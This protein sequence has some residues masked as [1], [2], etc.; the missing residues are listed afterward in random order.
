MLALNVFFFHPFHAIKL[1]I[2]E[3][4]RDLLPENDFR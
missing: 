4:D 1:V 2:T 3:S